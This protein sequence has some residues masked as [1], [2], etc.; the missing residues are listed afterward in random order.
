MTIY[1]LQHLI[2]RED[3][4][5]A[6]IIGIYSSTELA[7]AAA[8]KLSLAPG[9]KGAPQGF[10]IDAYELDKTFWQDGF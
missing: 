1:L 7:N 3:G 10:S 8:L 4:E 5:D 2:E 9:F 6:K